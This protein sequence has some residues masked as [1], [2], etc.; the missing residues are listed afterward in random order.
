MSPRNAATPEASGDG[1]V[2]LA[3]L[4]AATRAQV[5]LLPPEVRSR[6][7]LG[8][9]KLR[10][11][12]G[13]LVVLLL[14]GV[15]FVWASFQERN[16]TSDLD[17]A[18]SD[19]QDLVSQQAKYA[20]V[21]E[22]K[23]KVAAAEAARLFGMSTEVLWSDYLGRLAL[24]LPAGAKIETIVSTMPSP[25]EAGAVESN[26]LAQPG[27]GTLTFTTRS[28]TVPDA[29]AWIEALDAIPG[30]SDATYSVAEIQDDE[31]TA[32]YATTSV[33][34]VNQTAFAGRFAAD[35]EGK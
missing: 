29:A 26:P 17:A 7:A 5:N 19:V 16:A 12:L 4:G 34:Q 10:L 33:V 2:D 22:V 21:P 25:M 14:V 27:V 30:F 20:E 1:S 8:Q 15:G 32:Y 23:G 35:E 9:V 31:G 28:P 18:K 3:G 11:G 6:R 24:A 13:L